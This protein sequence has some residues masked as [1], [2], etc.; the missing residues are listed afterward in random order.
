MIVTARLTSYVKI[1]SLET[2]LR[3]VKLAVG[4]EVKRVADR[5]VCADEAL[6]SLLARM[7]KVER[8]V[9]SL[10]ERDVTRREDLLAAE[11]E[12]QHLQQDKG[13]QA[14]VEFLLRVSGEA[15]D[16]LH[17][18]EDKLRELAQAS[19]RTEGILAANTATLTAAQRELAQLAQASRGSATKGDVLQVRALAERACKPA[20][21]DALHAAV[22]EAQ[23]TFEHG[24]AQCRLQVAGLHA[25]GGGGGGGGF[26]PAV[27]VQGSDREL[28]QQLE[29]VATCVCSLAKLVVPPPA[30]QT[31]RRL[32]LSVARD[33]LAHVDAVWRWVAHGGHAPPLGRLR[34]HALD[35][36]DGVP[37]ALLG[38]ASEASLS[39]RSAPGKAQE[40]CASLLSARSAPPGLPEGRRLEPEP[41]RLPRISAADVYGGGFRDLG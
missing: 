5:Q 8:H 27:V 22:E 40:S 13:A 26:A 11:Q 28:G 41:V 9:A 18:A 12:L 10:Q 3:K 4:Q 25:G 19:A 32:R 31:S 20:S 38:S 7:D 1:S 21:L 35:I 6:A 34:T 2:R 24:L 15:R 29:A 37:H 17:G 33:L 36:S 39:A 16:G 23:R 30:G 14:D